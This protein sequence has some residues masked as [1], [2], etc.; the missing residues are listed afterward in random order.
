MQASPSM[1][2][3]KQDIK[4]NLK[5]FEVMKIDGQPMDKDLNQLKQKLSKM[6][7]SIPTTNGGRM[8]GRLG[9][10]FSN[11]KYILFSNGGIQFIIPN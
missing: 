1:I 3:I 6:A 8:H 9:I 2:G 7:A 5:D 11:A 10:I 4:N